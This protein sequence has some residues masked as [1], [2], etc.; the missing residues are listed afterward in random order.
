MGKRWITE[1][2]K[3]R[4]VVSSSLSGSAFAWPYP[5]T[6]RSVNENHTK[7]TANYAEKKC[8]CIQLRAFA[9]LGSAVEVGH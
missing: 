9:R 3:E 2:E 1:G 4:T 6:L 7:N 8:H 5:I